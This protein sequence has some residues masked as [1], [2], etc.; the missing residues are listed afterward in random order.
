MFELS[1]TD[2]LVVEALSA[3]LFAA[4]AVAAQRRAGTKALAAASGLCA[5]V[6]LVLGYLDWRRL[7]SKETPL[8]AYAVT[9]I[10]PTTIAALVIYRARKR[11]LPTQWFLGAAGFS[12]AVF[13]ALVIGTYF[14]GELIRL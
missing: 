9:A 6:L 13:P 11:P 10:V 8:V 4:A 7:T 5:A 14:L 2:Y 3:A 12:L 1:R